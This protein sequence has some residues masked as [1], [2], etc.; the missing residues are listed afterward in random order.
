MLLATLFRL[1]AMKARRSL[2]LL[3]MLACPLMVVLLNT[4]MLLRQVG[5]DGVPP[6]AWEGFWLGN[7]ALWCYFMLPLYLALCTALVN[8]VEHRQHGWRL[9]LTLPVGARQLYL[10]KLLL[11]LVMAAIAHLCL[12]LFTWAV[13]MLPLGAPAPHGAFGAMTIAMLGALAASL[14]VLVLQHT[15]SWTS[16]NIVTPLALGVCATMGVIQL[17]SS[18]HWRLFPGPTPD[19]SQRQRPG[20][21]RCRPA[22][23]AGGR[24][25][26]AGAGLLVGRTPAPAGVIVAVKLTSSRLNRKDLVGWAALPRQSVHPLL[27]CRPR[28]QPRPETSR[29]IACWLNAWAAQTLPV[30][31]LTGWSRPPYGPVHGSGRKC[32]VTCAS[33]RTG[34]PDNSFRT[35]RVVEDS[36]SVRRDDATL[37]WRC[38]R[39]LHSMA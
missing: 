27:E 3:M 25:R 26:V 31:W 19:G 17:G 38:C 37:D 39:A 35:R 20:H 6:R 32:D 9:M 18:E 4:G 21:A 22:A 36:T 2:A 34:A 30:R 16:Q 12:L 11:A 33:G 23:R 29:G 8:G 5:A 13:T 15:L 10:A 14:P 7:Q 24:R 1:E 28:V